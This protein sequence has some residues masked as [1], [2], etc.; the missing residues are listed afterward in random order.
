MYDI[1][2]RQNEYRNRDFAKK[3]AEETAGEFIDKEFKDCFGS[4]WIVLWKP[5][6]RKEKGEH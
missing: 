3:I 1:L 2:G 5:D 4:Y 6:S